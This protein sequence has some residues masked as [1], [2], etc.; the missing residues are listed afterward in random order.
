[1]IAPLSFLETVS[2]DELADE[3][4]AIRDRIED[5]EDAMGT[6]RASLLLGFVRHSLAE[7]ASDLRVAAEAERDED[8]AAR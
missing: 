1:V 4:E 8:G 2:L 3:L 7:A 5:H 6:G